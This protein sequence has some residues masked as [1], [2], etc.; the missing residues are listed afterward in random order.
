MKSQPD[1]YPDLQ[2]SLMKNPFPKE[3]KAKK[4]KKKK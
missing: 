2:Q 3:K 4:K 1:R